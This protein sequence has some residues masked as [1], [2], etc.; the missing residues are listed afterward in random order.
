V[1][2]DRVPLYVRLPRDQAA[3]LD[4]LASATGRRKQRLVSEMLSEHM[5][6]GRAEL[7]D[8]GAAAAGEILTLEE[9][10]ALLRVSDDV[11]RARAQAGELPARRFGEEWR[12]ARSALL[13]WLAQG[14]HD[15]RRQGGP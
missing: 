1:P 7:V 11:L 15:E 13:A 4:R 6:V 10:A 9:A 8:G 2:D 14:E 3:E 5:V 12:F